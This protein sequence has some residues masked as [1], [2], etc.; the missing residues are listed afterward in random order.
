M[1]GQAANVAV[2][3][4]IRHFRCNNCWEK[5]FDQDGEP[6]FSA[7]K[8]RRCNH[9]VCEKCVED[10]QAEQNRIENASAPHSPRAAA[11]AAS[12]SPATSAR[13]AVAQEFSNDVEYCPVC[14]RRVAFETDVVEITRRD[15]FTC[16]KPNAELLKEICLNPHSAFLI[17]FPQLSASKISV[18]GVFF[19][20]MIL[21]LLCCCSLVDSVEHHRP[22]RSH[23]YTIPMASTCNP[24][25]TRPEA[26]AHE[27]RVVVFC[28]FFC[29]MK[30]TNM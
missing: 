26:A 9:L 7:Y 16:A 21:I 19:S 4:G 28:S 20:R 8:I 24:R 1:N 25:A 11:A 2:H 29:S 10:F 27:V 6:G 15:L 3:P 22:R 23:I 14:R 30:S 5:F 12:S 17:L 18:P 13:D